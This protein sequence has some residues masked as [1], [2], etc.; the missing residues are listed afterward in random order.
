M[1]IY[2]M[3]KTRLPGAN[4][5][6]IPFDHRWTQMH[7][8]GRIRRS[9]SGKVYEGLKYIAPFISASIDTIVTD[10]ITRVIGLPLAPVFRLSE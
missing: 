4:W 9:Y 2:P 7:D 10:G 5:Y 6:T 3:S 8:H 1:C